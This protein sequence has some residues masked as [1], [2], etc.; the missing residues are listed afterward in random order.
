MPAKTSRQSDRYDRLSILLHWATLALLVAAFASIEGRVLFE[1]R[2]AIRTFTKEAHYVLGL[3]ILLVTLA[4][5]THR[6]GAGSRPAINP[7][8]AAPLKIAAHA[9]AA[10]LYAMLLVTPVLGFL[11]VQVLG[12]PINLGFGLSFPAIVGSEKEV[13]KTIENLHAFFGDTMYVLIGA[14]ALAALM[15]HYLFR[16]TALVNMAPVMAPARSGP[17]NATPVAR[18]RA[19]R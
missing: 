17:S 18:G 6:L 14:H 8:P 16:D 15:H 5:L 10:L 19:S 1:R 9:M 4:R 3:L 12:D 2:T 7:P 13:G 11:S